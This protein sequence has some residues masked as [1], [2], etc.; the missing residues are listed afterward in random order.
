MEASGGGYGIMDFNVPQK[1]RPRKRSCVPLRI[2]LKPLGKNYIYTL[3]DNLAAVFFFRLKGAK[4]GRINKTELH[5]NVKIYVQLRTGRE[6][7]LKRFKIN[8][9]RGYLSL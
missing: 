4:K 8:L 1:P 3:Y 5:K 9:Y 7:L 2:F 6:E